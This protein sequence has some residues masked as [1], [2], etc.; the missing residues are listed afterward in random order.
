M[1]LQTCE[2][3]TPAFA[4][5]MLKMRDVLHTGKVTE[6]I[7]SED[8]FKQGYVARLAHATLHYSLD[9]TGLLPP[10]LSLKMSKA[11]LPNYA[12]KP[13]RLRLGR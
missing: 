6:V 10:S 12:V 5:Q 9:A 3:L 11:D 13:R 8:A 7:C 1:I 2:Q 4:T